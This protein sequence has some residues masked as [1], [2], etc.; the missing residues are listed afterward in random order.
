VNGNELQASCQ[1]RNGGWR[2]TSLNN[3]GQCRDIENDNGK[4][5]CR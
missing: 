1:K 3:F 2:N 4:L 5:K